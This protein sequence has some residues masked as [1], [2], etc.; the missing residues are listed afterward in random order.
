MV[1][2]AGAR[3]ENTGRQLLEGTPDPWTLRIDVDRLE[4]VTQHVG[5]YEHEPSV[6]RT[7]S[8]RRFNFTRRSSQQPFRERSDLGVPWLRR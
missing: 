6:P 8:T 2:A 3:Q 1:V 4:L 7:S 5:V